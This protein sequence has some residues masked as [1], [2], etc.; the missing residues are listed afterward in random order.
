LEGAV[1]IRTSKK[2]V[3][4]P[5]DSAQLL[6]GYL[7]RV[8][9]TRQLVEEIQR[10]GTTQPLLLT[11][12]WKEQRA[13]ALGAYANERGGLDKLPAG[14]APLFDAVKLDLAADHV[15]PGYSA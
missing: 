13:A 10:A 5:W 4:L 15:G 9:G 11:H 6:Q 7:G 12:H 14:M 1:R 8:A 3:E 2:T